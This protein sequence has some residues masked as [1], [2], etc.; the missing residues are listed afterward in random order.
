M[1]VAIILIKLLNKN[2][3]SHDAINLDFSLQHIHKPAS[4]EATAINFIAGPMG[5][6]SPNI[7]R[8]SQ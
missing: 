6:H 1:D 7:L 4:I 8:I 2:T 3:V 5:A